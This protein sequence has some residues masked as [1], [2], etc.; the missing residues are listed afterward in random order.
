MEKLVNPLF[1]ADFFDSCFSGSPDPRVRLGPSTPNPP[2]CVPAKNP[3]K[4]RKPQNPPKTPP[5]KEAWL[6]ICMQ[7]ACVRVSACVCWCICG[8]NAISEGRASPSPEKFD[9]LICDKGGGFVLTS[10][11]KKTWLS[12]RG[13]GFGGFATLQGLGCEPPFYLYRSQRYRRRGG[14]GSNPSTTLGRD[15]LGSKVMVIF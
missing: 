2:R 3:P 6:R 7:I 13:E 5:P 9:L 4:C 8:V 14:G 15:F 12:T 11:V 10:Q 1:L